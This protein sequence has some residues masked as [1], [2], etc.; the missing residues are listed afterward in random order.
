MLFR[1]E[2]GL[3]TRCKEIQ[4]KETEKCYITDSGKRIKKDMFLCVTTQLINTLNSA[5]LLYQTYCLKDDMYTAK[6]LTVEA[7]INRYQ[8][9]KMNFDKLSNGLELFFTI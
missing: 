6:Q 2:E 9:L 4:V 5:I 3:I 8:E 7:T 1:S